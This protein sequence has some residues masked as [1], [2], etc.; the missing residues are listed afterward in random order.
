MFVTFT[1]D[2]SVILLHEHLI[3]SRR[4]VQPCDNMKWWFDDDQNIPDLIWDC[5]GNAGLMNASL[6]NQTTLTSH[7]NG[8][9]AKPP[10]K[11]VVKKK[12]NETQKRTGAMRNLNLQSSQETTTNT[13]IT[14]QGTRKGFTSTGTSTES[15]VNGIFPTQLDFF[16][17][18]NFS[19]IHLGLPR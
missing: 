9:K 13:A 14:K 10:I 4:F 5:P 18:R 7:R 12:K 16:F 8:R 2:V 19:Q 3:E 1:L 6:K 17:I 15:R 11:C